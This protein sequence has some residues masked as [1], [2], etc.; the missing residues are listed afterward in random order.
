M[1]KIIYNK[2]IRDKIPEIIKD[3]GKESSTR[4]LSYEEYKQELLKKLVEEAQELLVSGG[5]LSER[6]D[7]AEVLRAVD[8]IFKWS[9]EDIE[10]ARIHKL[11]DRGGF[12]ERLYL[13]YV[14]QAP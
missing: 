3:Q 13:E 7:V 8:D 5:D 6:A 12:Q 1:K 14:T 9:T 2:L 4:I 11:K 10:K